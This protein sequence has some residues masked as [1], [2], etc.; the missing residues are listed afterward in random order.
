MG[1]TLKIT[2][3]PWWG[4]VSFTET[5]YQTAEKGNQSKHTVEMGKL[6]C[7]LKYTKRPNSIIWW[8]VYQIKLASMSSNKTEYIAQSKDNLPSVPIFRV[9][10]NH[11]LNNIF[12]PCLSNIDNERWQKK[13]RPI[14][15]KSLWLQ[16]Y[17]SRNTMLWQTLN[18]RI[19]CSVMSCIAW[20]GQKGINKV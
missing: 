8:Y 13:P 15:I 2:P 16:C 19:L 5:V 10:L 18:C 14:N 17:K 12:L 3:C 1:L 6:Y 4:M 7:E 11:I 20:L 9:I